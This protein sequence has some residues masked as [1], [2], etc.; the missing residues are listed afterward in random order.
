MILLLTKRDRA[1]LGSLLLEIEMVTI[2][3]TI[4]VTVMVEIIMVTTMV[5]MVEVDFISK[6]DSII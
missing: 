4:M 3:V 5:V 2:M 6:K 1:P